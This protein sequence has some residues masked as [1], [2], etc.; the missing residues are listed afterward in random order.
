MAPS[1]FVRET[2]SRRLL[3][4]LP[5]LCRVDD[6]A[7]CKEPAFVDLAAPLG[8][9][10]VNPTMFMTNPSAFLP[11]EAA[12]RSKPTG[13]PR[14]WIRDTLVGALW[15]FS[16]TSSSEAV[17]RRLAAPGSE[18][19]NPSEI[20]V[21]R[22][23]TLL[24]RPEELTRRELA[25]KA[26]A[27]SAADQFR[28]H[29][30]CVLK[31]IVHPAHLAALAR[32]YDALVQS[33]RWRLGDRQVSHRYSWSNEQAARFF[34]HQLTDYLGHVLGVRI[35]PT[36]SF[37]CL[38]LGGASLRRHT[39]RAACEFTLSLAVGH[40]PRASWPLKLETPSGIAEVACRPGEPSCSGATL[41]TFVTVYR[42]GR[43]GPL[44]FSIMCEP[45]VKPNARE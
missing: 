27:G 45:G 28:Q 36:Y 5:V 30:W 32:R 14:V 29:G 16:T 33:G 31:D 13:L 41:L 44:S 7:D 26:Q 25:G 8:A 12:D 20:T 43:R 21:L 6:V 22:K 1:R 38:Y 17:V 19:L 11:A 10:I 18:G 9:T 24:V 23:T 37:V 15:P 39:D 40:S 4:T 2:A 42:Q 3:T 35:R 34:H